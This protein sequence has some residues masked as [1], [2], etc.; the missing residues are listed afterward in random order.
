MSIRIGIRYASIAAALLAGCSAE[1]SED[2]GG[3][4]EDARP[5]PD[6]TTSDLPTGPDARDAAAATCSAV[7]GLITSDGLCN[8]VPFPSERVPFVVG[9][10][11][12]PAFTGGTLVDGLYAAIKAE[13]WN[14][15]T[16][17]GRQMGIVLMNGGKTMLWFGQVLNPDGSGDPYADGGTAGLAWLRANFDLSVKTSNTL[18]LTKTCGAG[19]AGGP[20]ELLYT[21]TT[22]DPPQ[23]ILANPNPSV[24]EPTSAVT[25]YER[26]G[27]P[28]A[29]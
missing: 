24:G 17:S 5:G 26:R 18:A 21:M 10:G 9:T 14:V 8:A 4:P 1:S 16:G 6:L 29:P 27:C 19:T 28:T 15:T 22:T 20:P 11:S 2:G 25:T 13:G 23:L 3:Q 12:P 7:A